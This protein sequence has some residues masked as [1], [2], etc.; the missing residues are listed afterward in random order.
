MSDQVPRLGRRITAA[1]Q[2]KLRTLFLEQYRM[3]MDSVTKGTRVASRVEKAKVQ[4]HLN[5]LND[6]T[7]RWIFNLERAVKPVIW[8]SA[9]FKHA[10]GIMKGKAFRPEPWETWDIMDLFG[11]EDRSTGVR[12][13]NQAYWQIPRKNGKST[14]AGAIIDYLAFGDGYPGA[15]CAVASNSLEQAG[16]TFTRAEQGLNLGNLPGIESY[17]SRTYKTIKWG[18]CRV[19]ALTGV[20]KDGK[21]LH[22]AILDE[23][24]ESR[25][26]GMLNSFLTGNIA[27]PE[28]LVLIITTAGTYLQGPCHQEYEKCIKIVSQAIKADRYWVAIYEPDQG[29]QPGDPVTWEKANPNL[30]VKGSVD[31]DMM[32][33]RYEKSQ[34]SASDLTVFKTK[35]LNMWVHSTTKWANME[36][37]IQG[38]SGPADVE[39]GSR[40]YA[41]VDL[42][43]TSDFT[44][45]TL[46][47]PPM[48]KEGIHKQHYMF[49]I[50]AEN[51]SRI[52][53]QCSVPLEQ[54]IADGYVVAT[55]GPVID[56]SYIAEYLQ[57]VREQYEL[58]LIAGD[59]FR[60]IDLAR[61]CPPWFEEITFEFSQGKMTMSPSTQ[62]FER[63]YLLG[64]IRSGANPV[65]TWMMSCVD[66]HTDSNANVK[67]IKP[68]HDRSASR[69]DGVIASIMALDTAI[70]QEPDGISMDELR[71][72][73]SF[74]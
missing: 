9:N 50:P 46:D 39:P 34:H 57:R 25:D 61:Y 60:L 40:C 70:T 17:N 32:R 67:L 53:R 1:T 3:Y 36:K 21:L 55:P 5:T 73:I 18:G 56:Y 47:F 64:R 58:Q 30:G 62:Q 41:G 6:P 33:D 72:M 8:I 37:W 16:E 22:G 10:L 15:I 4:R 71:D 23:F 44:A 48:E 65:M 45:I 29:D 12:R 11:W 49:F 54:W 20:P 26:T 28:S 59:R 2:E 68:Q 74:F 35:N 52:Q 38:C 31:L 69:I 63:F 42:S 66:A 51:V 19:D 24:H 14:L 43:S 13:Y 27:D 7:S